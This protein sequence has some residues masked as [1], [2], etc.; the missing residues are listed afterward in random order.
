MDIRWKQRFS[1]Y[2][3]AFNKL[4]E[5]VRFIL[6]KKLDF[7]IVLV[8]ITKEGLVQRFEY[9]HELAWKVFKDYAEYQGI[10][11]IG[12]SRDATREALQLNLID[13]GET[14]MDMIKSRNET[15]H[16][17]NNEIAAEIFEKIINAYFPL[18]EKFKN[19]MES[20]ICLLD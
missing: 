20:K 14:W 18:L 17:Y 4:D 12:G 1:N 2:V 3:R 16:T 13:N 5:A 10:N 6:C 7:D 19:K 11:E 8:E 9:T 15:S